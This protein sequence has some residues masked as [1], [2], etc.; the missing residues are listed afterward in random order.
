[1]PGAGGWLRR[2]AW[3]VALWL[4]GVA[5]VGAAALVIRLAIMG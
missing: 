3:F 2:I 4:A 1:M 5:A